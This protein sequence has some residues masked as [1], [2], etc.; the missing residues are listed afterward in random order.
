MDFIGNRDIAVSVVDPE[1]SRGFY[2]GVLGLT[3]EKADDGLVVYNTGSF[4]LYVQQGNPLP[5]V[6]S[7]TVP[8]LP[9]ARDLLVSNGCEII[10]ER[11]RSLYFSD[12]DGNIW[13][14]IEG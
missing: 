8:D 12:P 13:D 1:K 9:K 2:E 11:E 3:P 10:V 4:T 6:P 7:F 5:P 14:I